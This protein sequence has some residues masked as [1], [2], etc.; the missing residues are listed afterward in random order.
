MELKKNHVF[1]GQAELIRQMQVADG[2]DPCYDTS[3]AERCN[4][5]DCCWRYDCYSEGR[6]KNPAQDESARNYCQARI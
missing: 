4:N 3:K 6:E 1:S 5:H 2:L